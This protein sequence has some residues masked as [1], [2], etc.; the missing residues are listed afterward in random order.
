MHGGVIDVDD[1]MMATDALSYGPPRRAREYMNQRIERYLSVAKEAP[2]AFLSG[3]RE[4]YDEIRS[5]E[6]ARKVMALTNR[7]K[8][9]W[10]VNEIRHLGNLRELRQAPPVM[11]RYMM[12]NPKV[13]KLYHNDGCSG[14][15][16]AYVDD[17]PGRIK[18]DHYD[19]RRVTDEIYYH[20]TEENTV[21]FS[22][23]YESVS[24]EVEQL[25]TFMA[26]TKILSSWR[27]TED[28]LNSGSNLDPV[29]Q[30]N[31]LL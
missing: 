28:H 15:A 7:L 19:F 27:V 3:I 20:D 18:K 22:K 24:A 17:S 11:R 31:G 2:S 26:K 14:Y 29:S 23:H 25:M 6:A 10:E 4:R 8:A 5:G 1:I 16:E 13:R 21:E 30:W 9:I 12:A